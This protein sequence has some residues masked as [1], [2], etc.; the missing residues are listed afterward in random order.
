MPVYLPTAAIGNGRVLATLGGR[1]EIMTAFYPHIDFA[2]NVH[3][4]LPALYIGEP[5]Q[6]R[7]VWAYEDDFTSSQAYLPGTNILRT[8]LECRSEAVEVTLTDFVPAPDDGE[9]DS[10]IIREIAIANHGR[11]EFVGAFGQYFDLR[12]GEVAGKQ[13]VRYDYPT[14]RFMQYFRDIA[15]VV[16]GAV[17][18]Q[19]RCGKAGYWDERSA[20]NDL[21]DGYLNGQAEDIGDVDFAQL[22]ALRL[23]PGQSRTLTIIIAFATDLH[24]AEEALHRLHTIGP[25]ALLSRTDAYWHDYLR[26]RVPV[27]VGPELEQAYERALL[28]L[29]LL[30]DRVT[31]SFVAAPEFDP[32]YDKCGGY[33]YCWPRDAS[34]AAG[35]LAVAGYPESVEA[36]VKWYVHSQL[37]GGMWGQRHWAEGPIAASWSMREGFRQ[38]DQSAAGL[39]TVSEWA[40]ADPDAACERL[41]Q[42]YDC[43][44]AAADALADLVDIRGYHTSACDL[45]ETFEGVFAYTNAA[46]SVSLAAA[47]RCAEAR[48]D[49]EAA[50][51]WGAVAERSAAAVIELFNGTYFNRG[52]HNGGDQDT[53]VDSATLGLIEPFG[54]LDLEDPEHRRMVRENLATIEATLG[55]ETAHGPAIARYVGDGYLGGTVGCVNT[56]WTA[57]VK[58]T[59]ALAMIDTERA[60]ADE[61]VGDALTYINTAL[62][63]A[64][65]PGCL[66]ELM[67]AAEFAWWAAPHSW[68][69]ALLVKCVLLYDEWLRAT[70]Q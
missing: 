64:T 70:N 13:A 68:A 36:L 5:G 22:F 58:L 24:G 54:V 28:M 32:Q 47:A 45:W 51:R 35:A 53:T 39:L 2:Q 66:P 59:L 4:L 6:G 11:S 21:P 17:P 30:Q 40:L 52:L 41:D 69:S 60:A 7:L 48:G 1:G 25:Q 50:R 43:V 42:V 14:G 61:M 49:A 37:P 27:C 12:L 31:G 55:R 46:F 44:H 9:P 34:E 20:K 33:G 18:D 62:R 8:R 3:E 67:A 56:L 57:Q 23:P 26:R 16:G 15:V 29:G 19:V 65:Q 63:H 10:A 38:L